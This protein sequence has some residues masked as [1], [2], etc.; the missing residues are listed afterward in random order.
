MVE[1]EAYFG[2][3]FK[4]AKSMTFRLGT[5]IQVV[6]GKRDDEDHL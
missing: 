1:T 3:T 6:G 4:R 2:L 5:D